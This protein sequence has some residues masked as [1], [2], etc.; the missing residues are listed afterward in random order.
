MKCRL[1]GTIL[2]LWNCLL[3]ASTVFAISEQSSSP[4]DWSLDDI[5]FP[6]SV[7]TNAISVI[8]SVPLN[9]KVVFFETK[10]GPSEIAR[11]GEEQNGGGIPMLYQ[12]NRDLVFSKFAHLLSLREKGESQT[13]LANLFVLAKILFPNLNF[14]EGIKKTRVEGDQASIDQ[15]FTDLVN[16]KHISDHPLSTDVLDLLR[17]QNFFPS[18][19]N[20]TQWIKFYLM[21]TFFLNDHLSCSGVEFI[22]LLFNRYR[23]IDHGRELVKF[24]LR[25]FKDKSW[26]LDKRVANL[27]RELLKYTKKDE[28]KNFANELKYLKS[29]LGELYLDYPDAFS[30]VDI[31]VS[32]AY[33]D[34]HILLTTKKL[35]KKKRC[36]QA[37]RILSSAMDNE[38]LQNAGRR[39]TLSSAL[40]GVKLVNSCFRK[41]SRI[42]QVKALKMFAVKMHQAFGHAGSSRVELELS[43]LYWNL[44]RDSDA[45]L[46]VDRVYTASMVTANAEL[47]AESI[48]IKASIFASLHDFKNAVNYYK[49]FL[50]KFPDHVK[51]YPVLKN[52]I[53]ICSHQG[54]WQQGLAFAKLLLHFMD[55]N[56]SAKDLDSL[57]GF[58]LFWAGR[59]AFEV[60]KDEVA[61][62]YWQML[63]EHYSPSYYGALAHYHL[64]RYF[65]GKNDFWKKFKKRV[66]VDSDFLGQLAGKH[67]G[68]DR[69]WALFRL[70]LKKQ[71]N[72]ELLHLVGQTEAPSFL[73]SR[74]ILHYQFDHF[75]PAIKSI[76]RL[77]YS[78]RGS[79][80]TAVERIAFP[81]KYQETIKEYAGKVNIDDDLIL[82]IIRQESAFN[83]RARSAAGAKGLMQLMTSTA[84]AETHKL[85][86]GYLGKQKW[87]KVIGK[88]N[89]RSAGLFEME[90]NIALG[91]SYFSHLVD[92]FDNLTFSLAAYNAGPR[93]VR[94]WISRYSGEIDILSFIEHIPYKETQRYVKLIWRNYFY[95]KLYY[96]GWHDALETDSDYLSQMT[97]RRQFEAS[98]EITATIQDRIHFRL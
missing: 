71:A 60:H 38:R 9:Q 36:R 7:E 64:L 4:K 63:V 53:N 12:V 8:E 26:I 84:R 90:T 77:P 22:R 96:K 6:L 33:G 24:V 93:A 59:S 18:S 10:L 40:Q 58:A 92:K 78:F 47:E 39:I 75:L 34:E 86:K 74:G 81:K 20:Q 82:A 37:Q 50:R 19:M 70:G 62:H 73:L 23:G 68:L 13:Y 87:K 46:V 85:R 3:L 94:R 61:I 88:I 65:Q 48:Y 91:V 21:Q 11:F 98:D 79:L 52:L 32:S 31:Q 45:L 14:E 25:F 2:I 42:K 83:V 57:I 89:S 43:R 51:I 30:Q 49:M 69:A 35:V 28:R 56:R 17:E 66:S 76:T 67:K 29:G 95:Y 97:R 55:R 72:C 54:Q 5:I 1:L 44:N 16:R 15:A 27:V 41:T 80:P